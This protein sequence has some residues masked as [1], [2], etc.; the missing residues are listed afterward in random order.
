MDALFRCCSGYGPSLTHLG[1]ARIFALIARAASGCGQRR[2]YD[3]AWAKAWA[4]LDACP[5]SEGKE[6]IPNVPVEP[7]RAAANAEDWPRVSLATHRYGHLPSVGG[8]DPQ[9]W[10][11]LREIAARGAAVAASDVRP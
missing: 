4:S 1:R 3:E 5:L 8:A 7:A 9:L 10:M 6:G 2:V 11:E